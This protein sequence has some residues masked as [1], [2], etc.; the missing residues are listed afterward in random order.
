MMMSDESFDLSPEDQRVV[1][2]L[3]E[4]GFDPETIRALPAEDRA[5]A[6]RLLGLMDLLGDYPVEDSDDALVHATM[7]RVDRAEDERAAR[8]V[9][10]VSRDDASHRASGRR[11]RLPDFISIAAVMLIA[12]GVLWPTM[13]HFR[14]RSVDLQCSN[15]LRQVGYAF[16]NYRADHAD[17]M[18]MATASFGPWKGDVKHV[19]NLKPL[20]EHGYCDHGHFDCPG[21]HE[22]ADAS[23]SYQWQSADRPVPWGAGQRMTL[24][25]G[26][27][28]PL[29]D[30]YRER[31]P[32]LATAASLNHGGRGQNALAS[33][34]STAW[35]DQPVFMGRDNIWLPSGVLELQD[36]IGCDE[37]WDVF[38]A[39]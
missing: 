35:L 2:V 17:A 14:Q 36:G 29:I 11:I 18:P 3:V 7:A 30:A 33:D 15:Q 22:Y 26:D 1:D 23:Y 28:N 21:V 20:V 4:S 25:L 12:A 37:P 24:V 34:G 31:R 19:V 32:V 10:D 38:L 5:R 16:S 6:E 13:S 9:F 27:R 39:H 8:M